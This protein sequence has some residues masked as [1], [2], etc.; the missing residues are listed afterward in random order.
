VARRVFDFEGGSDGVALT[1]NNTDGGNS[2]AAQITTNAGTARFSTRLVRSGNLGAR[3]VAAAN[4]L[5]IGRFPFAP[6][7][8]N[9][10]SINYAFTLEAT[11]AT[12][13]TVLTIRFN[14]G[15][16]ARLNWNTDNSL[17]ILDTGNANPLVL[18]AGVTPGLGYEVSFRVKSATSTTGTITA[19]LYSAAGGEIGRA[20]S[21]TYNLGTAA[22]TQVDVGVVNTNPAAGTAVA[23]DYLQM[24]DGSTTELRAP[25]A[26]PAYSGTV[27][28]TATVTTTGAGA[29]GASGAATTTATATASGA[30]QPATSGSAATSAAATGTGIG[31]ATTS[32]ASSATP[33]VT[34][35]ATG[36][37]AAAGSASTSAVVISTGNGTAPSTGTGTA[38]AT[39]TASGT[40]VA[41]LY[42]VAATV[43]AITASAQGAAAL[44]GSASA[45]AS[46]TATGQGSA[47]ARG[48]GTTYPIASSVT[49]GAPSF[50][51]AADTL[52]TVTALGGPSVTPHDVDVAG[53]LLPRRYAVALR[54]RRYDATTLPN[55]WKGD[56]R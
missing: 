12:T 6:V 26:S 1:G 37:P 2:G 7:A 53:W 50:S 44:R 4:A 42:G 20:T 14:G 29:P 9:T 34:T 16:A 40:G 55:R 3:F 47:S 46:A 24:D 5:S 22:L 10:Q 15:V 25:Q 48:S 32:G 30:V 31:S 52:V 18:S 8:N 17:S 19:V 35:T 38:T 36:S 39:V 43:A 23:L 51:G 56:L 13:T 54:P 49:D 28:T 27:T 21:S 41:T 45:A 33:T 11:P